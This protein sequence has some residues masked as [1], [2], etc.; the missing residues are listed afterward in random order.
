M[1]GMSE[2]A[3]D[4]FGPPVSPWE[5]S[6]AHEEA[7][8]LHGQGDAAAVTPFVMYGR[9]MGGLACAI[10]TGVECAFGW[11]APKGSKA[12]SGVWSPWRGSE[13]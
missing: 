11:T 1:S 4:Q 8:L 7:Q 9:S 2:A 10:A 5:V 6:R 3:W 13:E 12:L